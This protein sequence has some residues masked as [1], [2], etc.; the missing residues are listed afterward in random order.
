MPP[1]QESPEVL[2]KLIGLSAQ[3]CST[4]DL[5]FLLDRI[6]SDARQLVRAEAGS[7]FLVEP[8]GLRF[9]YVQN[10]VLDGPGG[11]R[12]RYVGSVLPLDDTS[13][14]GYCALSGRTLMIDDVYHLPPEAPY[15]FN[16]SFD[17]ATGYRTRSVLVV[18]LKTSQQKVVGVLQV[19]NA[20]DSAGRVTSFRERDRLMVEFFADNAAIALERSQMTR[21]LILR[22]IRMAQLRDPKETGEHVSRVGGYA[23]AIYEAWAARQGIPGDEAA[24]QRDLIKVAAMLHDVG[25]VAVSDRILKK[26]GRLSEEEFAALKLHTIAGA[27]LF[28]YLASELDHYACQIALNHHERWDG[29]GYPGRVED[30]WAEPMRCGPG[31]KGEEI[32]LAARV[33]SV[34]DVYDALISPRVY[35]DPWPEDKVLRMIRE[36]SGRHFDPAM[37]EA[38]FDAYD[39]I[40][41]VTR[42]YQPKAPEENP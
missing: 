14:A 10:E 24:R 18:P 22:M 9:T 27:R 26:P 17:Q 15:H 1:E 25:K 37:V 5:D 7:I 39:L 23:A 36:E 30:I 33:V 16:R 20:R 6:L 35:K 2:Q 13:L 38:F 31:K 42:R 28:P 32:P 11:G 19:I 8:Q 34:A 21:E 4:H 29:S 3:L 41:G 12:D 40:R